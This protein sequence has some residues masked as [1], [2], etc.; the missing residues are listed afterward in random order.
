MQL[1]HAGRQRDI[2]GLE[3]PSGLGPT[4]KSDELHGFPVEAM[5]RAQI[6]EV[7]R[8]FARAAARAREAGLDGVEVHGA[9][10]YLFTQFLS[11]AINTQGRRVRRSAREPGAGSCSTSCGR[12]APRSVATTTSR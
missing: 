8:A 9:N 2:G 5:T 3:F 11:S 4:S 6:D 7:T 10:G 12:S 1:A